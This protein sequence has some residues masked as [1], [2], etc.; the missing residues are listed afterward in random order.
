M[1]NA[2]ATEKR[3]RPVVQ[4]QSSLTESILKH[5]SNNIGLQ[6]RFQNTGLQRKVMV[7]LIPQKIGKSTSVGILH[8]TPNAAIELARRTLILLLVA[9]KGLG[10]ALALLLG[11][12]ALLLFLPPSSSSFLRRLI[13]GIPSASTRTV[14]VA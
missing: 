13:T 10:F 11:F 14:G 4:R 8:A 5:G 12:V 2:N 6:N 9:A 7:A 1:R 3:T